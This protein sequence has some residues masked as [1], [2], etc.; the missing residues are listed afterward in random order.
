MAASIIDVS[1][2]QT[3]DPA[4]CCFSTAKSL[5]AVCSTVNCNYR[6]LTSSSAGLNNPNCLNEEGSNTFSCCE[7]SPDL[8]E[9]WN[10]EVFEKSS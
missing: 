10:C 7:D 3:F 8:Y 5:G 2:R 4:P 1:K 6:G 9:R